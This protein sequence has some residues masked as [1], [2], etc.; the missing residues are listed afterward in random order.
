MIVVQPFAAGQQ[1]EQ[2]DVGRRVRE[3][4]VADLVAQTVD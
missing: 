2:A 1:R 4:L 3:I